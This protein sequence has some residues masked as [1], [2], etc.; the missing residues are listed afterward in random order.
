MN[1]IK[2][3][4]IMDGMVI[5]S[6]SL[7]IV[8]P[9]YARLAHGEQAIPSGLIVPFIDPTSERGYAINFA[10]QFASVVA[11]S[12]GNMSIEGIASI[13]INTFKVMD[14]LVRFNMREFSKGLHPKQFTNEQLAEFRNLIVQLQDLENYFKEVNEIYYWKFFL[15]PIATTVSVSLGIFSQMTVSYRR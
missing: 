13:I 9:L 10:I 6:F 15:H 8:G 11:S 7:I 3:T 1:L 2:H 12:I 4:I 5:I 14:D